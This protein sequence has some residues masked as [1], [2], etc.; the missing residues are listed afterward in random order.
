[1]RLRDLQLKIRS[2][3]NVT[4]NFPLNKPVVLFGPNNSGKSNIFRALE[5]FLRKIYS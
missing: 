2:V 5:Y 4:I 3:A 1:M